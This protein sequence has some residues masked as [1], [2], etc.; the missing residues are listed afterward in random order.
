M[1]LYFY[2]IYVSSSYIQT[3]I[4]TKMKPHLK[5]NLNCLLLEFYLI[6]SKQWFFD[7]L[8]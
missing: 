6:K 4:K 8:Q 2:I 5:Y 3:I 1:F 7:L